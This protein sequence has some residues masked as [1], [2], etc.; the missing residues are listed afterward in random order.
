ML[1]G[2]QVRYMQDSG[3]ELHKEPPWWSFVNI[4]H[5][6]Q[7]RAVFLWFGYFTSKT[8]WT[9]ALLDLFTCSLCCCLHAVVGGC[10]QELVSRR[11]WSELGPGQGLLVMAD[12]LVWKICF[13]FYYG[14][15]SA[16]IGKNKV[17]AVWKSCLIII[18]STDIFNYPHHRHF[19]LWN[20]AAYTLHSIIMEFFFNSE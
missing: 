9:K 1:L 14:K 8:T 16:R 20:M 15:S 17:N 6:D 13:H 7:Y 12:T 18:T 4:D 19:T 10:S 5:W 2:K 11:N 3:K